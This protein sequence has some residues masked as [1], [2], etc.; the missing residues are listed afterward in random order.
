MV[1]CAENVPK[2]FTKL[3]ILPFWTDFY[4]KDFLVLNFCKNI[5]T[6]DADTNYQQAHIDGNARAS[7]K[8]T[9]YTWKQGGRRGQTINKFKGLNIIIHIQNS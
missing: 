5:H 9:A 7:N 3:N 2:E 1:I 8:N 4:F 6:Q